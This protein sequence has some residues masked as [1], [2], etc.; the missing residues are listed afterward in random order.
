MPMKRRAAFTL[1]EILVAVAILAAIA[2]VA[3]PTVNGAIERSRITRMSE[4]LVAIAQAIREYEK[5][6]GTY[7]MDLDQ[8]TTK[9]IAGTD[10]NSC[11]VTLTAPEVAL[12]RGPYLPNALPIIE[13]EDTIFD[14]LKRKNGSTKNPD[15]LQISIRQPPAST[16]YKLDSIFDGDTDL[17][18]GTITWNT[19]T[20]PKGQ[21]LYSLPIQGC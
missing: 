1:V 20:F 14:N 18:D 16:A 21:M 15:I 8:L 12:W 19:N 9:P 11:G 2:A 5:H 10:K 4:D 13:G 6:V 3:L 17:S 7:P